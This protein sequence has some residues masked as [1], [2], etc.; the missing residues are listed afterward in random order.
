[1]PHVCMQKLQRCKKT[2]TY[3]ISMAQTHK[4]QMKITILGQRLFKHALVVQRYIDAFKEEQRSIG[5][6][7]IW[8]GW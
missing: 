7:G 1:M 6:K 3:N 4:G 2:A 8:F 5:N